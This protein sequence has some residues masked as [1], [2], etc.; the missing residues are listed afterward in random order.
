MENNDKIISI[1]N[2]TEHNETLN[3]IMIEIWCTIPT[4]LLKV[5]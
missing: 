2:K 4:S 3:R 1:K 5:Q